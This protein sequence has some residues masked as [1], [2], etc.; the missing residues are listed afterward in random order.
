[1]RQLRKAK[2]TAAFTARSVEEFLSLVPLLKIQGFCENHHWNL[3]IKIAK[4]SLLRE[5][6]GDDDNYLE[7]DEKAESALDAI[8]LNWSFTYTF[9]THI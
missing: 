6:S 9:R 5:R 7:V 4:F 2:K 3:R 1:M 8:I